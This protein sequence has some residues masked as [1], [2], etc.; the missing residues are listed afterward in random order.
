VEGAALMLGSYMRW[1][2]LLIAAIGAALL[3]STITGLAY[4]HSVRW[5]FSPGSRFT[6]SDHALATL[7][8]LDQP[9]K[10]TGFI[11]TGDARNVV[12]KDLLWQASR[13]TDM[14]HYSVVDVNRNPT[15]AAELGVEAY[16]ASIVESA[17]RRSEFTWPTEQS[18][19]SAI[20]HVTRPPKRVY[21]L[22]GH[23]E[24]RSTETDRRVGCSSMRTA[25][26]RELYEVEDLS[27]L[28]GKAVPAD[29]DVVAVVGPSSDLRE[30]EI[31]AL[32]AYL[33]RGGELLVLLEPFSAARLTAMLSSRGI[34]FADDVVLDLE[35]RLGGGEV[36]TAAAAERN[37][38]HAVTRGLDALPLFSGYRSVRAHANEE[39][40]EQSRWLLRSGDRS[41]GSRDP[42]VL[43]GKRAQFVA[44]RDVNGPLTI[45]LEFVKQVGADG[46]ESRIIVFGDSDFVNNRFLDYLGNRDLLVNTVNWLA[47]EQRMIAPRAKEKTP[48][49]NV[50]FVSAAQQK[51]LFRAAVIIQPGL[52]LFVGI[53]VFVWRRWSA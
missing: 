49:V 34:D 50:F 46:G 36:F 13:E 44:G 35:H 22:T 25:L 17:T 52:F 27:L 10:I 14:I 4:V 7:R 30:P 38:Q 45:G 32:E 39:A 1:V 18:L 43:R 12:L 2:Q 33:D 26:S 16:G 20:V 28:D 21:L 9:I 3:L 53:V 24:C 51:T 5:D 11:R 37:D 29:A 15:L 8:D 48:G 19:I 47:S 41:W 42:E 23:G 31:D 40:G 6:L